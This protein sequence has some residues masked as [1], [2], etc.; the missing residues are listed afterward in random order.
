MDPERIG[1]YEV[2]RL[3]GRGGMG[4]V[5]LALDGDG[6]TVA[7]KVIHP[8]IAEAGDGLVRLEREADAMTRLRSPHVAEIL[9]VDLRCATPYI[10]TRYVQ[11]RS[12][13]QIVTERG[14]FSGDALT[15]VHTGLAEAL[16]VIHREGVVHRDLTPRNVMLADGVPVV[17]DLGIAQTLDGTRITQGVIGTAGYVA[18]ELIEGERAGPPADVFAWAATVAFAATGRQC[19]GGR[20]TAEIF[21]NVLTR[22]PDLTGVPPEL[23]PVLERAL[24]KDPRRRPPATELTAPPK[25]DAAPPE[26]SRPAPPEPSRPA[27][28]EAEPAYDALR[29][30]FRD[31]L[32]EDDL[33][34]A[35]GAA[36]ELHRLASERRDPGE[37]AWALRA[38]AEATAAG[39][40]HVTA[41]RQYD[42]ARWLAASAGRQDIEAACL[43]GLGVCATARG[44]HWNAEQHH[45]HAAGIAQRIGNST[46]ES[47]SAYELA[48]AAEGRGDHAQA[49]WFYERVRQL[50]VGDG[51]R[52]TEAY[53]FL[54]LG[55]CA[56]ARGAKPQAAGLLQEALRIAEET[57]DPE[58]REWALDS[59]SNLR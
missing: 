20:T 50:A 48:F 45:R 38:I 3:L 22:R 25:P 4:S 2:L 23:L 12:L 57:G 46:I 44:D 27:P 32:A 21:N 26:P 7:V 47:L 58:A 39:G 28:A 51:D 37:I 33:T 41:A 43:H 5:Y 34:R 53:A 14:P 8:H 15:A 6:R 31:A 13:D 17:I 24:E 19:F 52:R 9:D 1:P 54:G 55:T 11:G 40:D 35:S 49:E 16:T 10:V 36:W 42:E 18:P 29:A 56:A 59:L 30:V